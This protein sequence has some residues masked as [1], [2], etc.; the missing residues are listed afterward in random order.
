MLLPGGAAVQGILDCVPSWHVRLGISSV[1]RRRGDCSRVQR[2]APE[3]ANHQPSQR[4][5][6]RRAPSRSPPTPRYDPALERILR[7]RPRRGR[8]FPVMN[9][10]PPGLD[11]SNLKVGPAHP[12]STRPDV[13][14]PQDC[15]GGGLS[16]Q[17]KAWIGQCGT[18][19]WLRPGRPT[20]V[21]RCCADGC[22]AGSRG[23][24]TVCIVE[25]N[26]QSGVHCSASRPQSM[27]RCLLH[28]TIWCEYVC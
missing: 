11:F 18:R 17:L 1:L 21:Q 10:I 15:W 26:A 25:G 5:P 22:G 9:V 4:T 28:P 23:R 13:P 27:P 14:V 2:S 12:I 7:A 24:E 19:R 16:A 20:P 3:H 8:H 6:F